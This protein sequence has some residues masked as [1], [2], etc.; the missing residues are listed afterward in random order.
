MLEWKKLWI[1]YLQDPISAENS[2]L[3]ITLEVWGEQIETLAEAK[4]ACKTS[5]LVSNPISWKHHSN[6]TAFIGVL[7]GFQDSNV[8]INSI[9]HSKSILQEGPVIQSTSTIDYKKIG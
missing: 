5:E 2:S 3:L 8:L 6:L 9:G 7:E 1:T 4:N